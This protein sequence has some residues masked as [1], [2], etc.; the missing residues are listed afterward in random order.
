MPRNHDKRAWLVIHV[1]IFIIKIKGSLSIP[2]LTTIVFIN[3]NL[4]LVQN[5]RC[6]VQTPCH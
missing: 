6:A 1:Y 3:L 2:P 4:I 5:E